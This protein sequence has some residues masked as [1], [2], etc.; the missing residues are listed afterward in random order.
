MVSKTHLDGVEFLEVLNRGLALLKKSGRLEE[1]G[2]YGVIAP[3]GIPPVQK[4]S[5]ETQQAN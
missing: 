5:G 4:N 1:I 3:A 2:G